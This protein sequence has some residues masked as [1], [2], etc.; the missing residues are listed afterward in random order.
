MNWS[1]VAVI[2]IIGGFAI[3]GLMNGFI[4]S[5]FRL[6]SF[7]VSVFIS[8]KF[9]PKISEILLKTRLYTGIR[10]S[11]FKNLTTQQPVFMPQIDSQAKNVVAETAISQI[12][13]P[14]FMKSMILDKIPSPSSLIDTYKLMDI[15]SDELTIAVIGI[16]SLILLYMLVSLALF[17]IK[18]ILKGVAK[19]PIFKQMDKFGGFAFGA[20]EGL[21]LVYLVCAVLIV[22]S[23]TPW[24]QPVLK[25]IDSSIAA[26]FFYKDNFIINWIF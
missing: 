24:F 17:F 26:N 21:L 5:I 11:I 13:L 23:A 2:S 6:A 7:F 9:Y 18:F 10:D 22:F 16:L 4:F 12:K 1:D 3:I 14:G 19:L 15:V 20:I 8:I 25:S